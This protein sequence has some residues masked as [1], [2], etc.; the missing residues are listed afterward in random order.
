MKSFS[1]LLRN[2]LWSAVTF[3]FLSC[4]SK[5]MSFQDPDNTIA[6]ERN[7]IEAFSGGSVVTGQVENF[8]EAYAEAGKLKLVERKDRNGLMTPREEKIMEAQYALHKGGQ[9]E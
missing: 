3:F 7:S 9:T 4:T 2:C 6:Q 1:A 5:Q 8:A